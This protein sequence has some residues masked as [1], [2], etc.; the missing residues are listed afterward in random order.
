M[1]IFWDTVKD[2]LFLSLFL[3]IA[4]I[5]KSKIKFFQRFLIPT[6]IIGGFI[7]LILGSG[8]L[9]LIKLSPDNL[10][11]LDYHLMAIGFIALALKDRKGSRNRDNVNTGF[12]IVSTYLAQGII[13]FIVSLVLAYTIF[14]NLFPH[15]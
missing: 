10:G 12:A 1:E 13:G 6:A 2:F 5:L 4:I 9:K 7:G 8:V 3:I 11:K 14:P 15:L